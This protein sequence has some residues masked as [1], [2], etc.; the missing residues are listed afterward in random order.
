MLMSILRSHPS[1]PWR[2]LL[3]V[4]MALPL[5]VAGLITSPAQAEPA[6]QA[7]TDSGITVSG[8]YNPGGSGCHGKENSAECLSWGLRV[9][10]TIAPKKD[11]TVTIEADSAPGQWVW[12][13]LASDRVAGTASF[14]DS[15]TGDGTRK[16]SESDLRYFA[17]LYYGI[18]GDSAGQ[19]DAITC[20][21]EHLSITY[22]IDYLVRSEGS[23]LDLSF[24]TTTVT[25]GSGEHT[26]SFSPT[27]TTSADNTPQKIT[28]TVQKPAENAAPR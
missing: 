1:R 12:N 6:P 21:P 14:Y 18:Y 20:T 19:V 2:R 4:A 17:H 3:G 27:V 24:G 10:S 5:L 22:K 13:C 23:Y 26:Y 8:S 7:P 28:A 9:P 16:L 11:L 15:P 25:P